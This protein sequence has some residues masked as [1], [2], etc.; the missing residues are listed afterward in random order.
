MATRSTWDLGSELYMA[1]ASTTEGHRG[2][3]Q[4]GKGSPCIEP[5][6]G[7][8]YNIEMSDGSWHIAEIVQKRENSSRETTRTEYYV[9]YR[10]CERRN[11]STH[12]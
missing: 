11:T 3:E 4:T 10:E 7:S 2:Q 6:A 8:C 5:T 9:H 12:L 1:M